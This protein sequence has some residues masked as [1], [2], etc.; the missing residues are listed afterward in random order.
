MRVL[1]I[2]A[3][4]AGGAFGV[5]LDTRGPDVLR[6][7]RE[8]I[9]GL[10][11]LSGALLLASPVSAADNRGFVLAPPEPRDNGLQAKW[12]EKLRIYLQ[13]EADAVQYG[14]ELAPGGPPSSTPLLLL[15]PILQM[16]KTLSKCSGPI[17]DFEQW[18][19]LQLLLSTG[20]FAPT[21]FKRIFNAYSDNIYYQSGSAE[22]NAYLLG[23]ATPSSQQTKQYLLR[24]EVLKQLGELTDEF[25]Y[26]LKL[27][28]AQR[29][30][31]VAEEYLENAQK[32]L[33]EYLS[34]APPEE[35]EAAK[36]AVY[37][38]GSKLEMAA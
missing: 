25:V 12:L 35:Y 14:G 3:A 21:E 19:R 7:R 33:A 16:Q 28:E 4:L 6:S 30:T 2:G 24:N 38:A 27:P 15:V 10:L 37:G 11:P 36:E 32:Y 23:G 17:K 13:D 5:R 34:L 26:Q 31:E 29:E 8:L 9:T 18:P 22:A 20:P 1:V